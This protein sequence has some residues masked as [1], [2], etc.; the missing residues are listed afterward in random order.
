MAFLT[1]TTPVFRPMCTRTCSSRGWLRLCSSSA[2]WMPTPQATALRAEAK[3]T[4]KP[5]PRP[6]T[7]WPLCYSTFWR[8]RPRGAAW[9]THY[10]LRGL[11]APTGRQVG[12]A[13]YVR[14]EDGDGAFWKLFGHAA[15]PNRTVQPIVVHRLRIVK[16]MN[17]MGT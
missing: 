4:M 11:V 2:R 5:S 10:L 9:G 15:N 7:S 1:R 12:G 13:H 17:T 3:A 8:V 14:E 6:F 16:E